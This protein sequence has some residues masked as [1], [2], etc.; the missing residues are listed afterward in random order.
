MKLILDN[1]VRSSVVEN[2]DVIV[3]TTLDEIFRR[4]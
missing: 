2:W 1:C 3:S 4:E